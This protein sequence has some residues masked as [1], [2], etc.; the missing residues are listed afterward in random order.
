VAQLETRTQKDRTLSWTADVARC[1]GWQQTYDCQTQH[2]RRQSHRIQHC[3]LLG[4]PFQPHSTTESI[5]DRTIAMF[6][7]YVCWLWSYFLFYTSLPYLLP[8]DLC[9]YLGSDL[10]SRFFE[11]GR[12]K[13]KWSIKIGG[14]TQ[15][16]RKFSVKTGQNYLQCVCVQIEEKKDKPR[17]R[18]RQR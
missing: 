9:L 2:P 17:A 12:V 4:L 5:G 16:N 3:T 13:F 15:I 1:H 14:Q 18:E 10:K 8:L 11:L 6:G 7:V